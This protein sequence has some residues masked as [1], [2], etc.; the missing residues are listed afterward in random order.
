MQAGL[1]TE[2]IEIHRKVK[3]KSDYGSVQT[4]YALRTATKAQVIDQGGSRLEE[5]NQIFYDYRK[6]FVV[7]YFIDVQDDDHILYENV[8]YRIL[9]INP[10]R[11]FNSKSIQCERVQE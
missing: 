8:W 6:T 4:S 11:K 10:E 1:L 9:N 2:P 7:R 3:A 5:N